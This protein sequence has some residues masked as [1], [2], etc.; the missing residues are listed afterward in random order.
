MWAFETRLE[1][2]VAMVGVKTDWS[3]IFKYFDILETT[4]F[5]CMSKWKSIFN[6]E[7]LSTAQ[8]STKNGP[9]K[10][11]SYGGARSL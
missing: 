2:L 3:E 8:S 7:T 4:L 5:T 10:V 6:Q 1:Y 9:Q 11:S